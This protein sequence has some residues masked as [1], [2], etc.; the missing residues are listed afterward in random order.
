MT[1]G[2]RDDKAVAESTRR[3]ALGGRGMAGSGTRGV[4]ERA[5]GIDDDRARTGGG[6]AAVGQRAGGGCAREPDLAH[7]CACT[8][9]GGISRVGD[10]REHHPVI[11]VGSGVRECD[12]G[13]SGGA[14]R[15]W[16]Q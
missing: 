13:V 7:L 2:G 14:R 16:T 12:V 6:G 1:I 9:T 15:R 11:P 5:V 3:R 10:S 8:G 4:G